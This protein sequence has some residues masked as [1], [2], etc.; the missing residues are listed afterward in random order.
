MSLDA[1]ARVKEYTKAL[2]VI[3]VTVSI[4]VK[5]N[6]GGTTHASKNRPRRGA[7]LC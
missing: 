6:D 4:M 1:C 3:Y 2:K 5:H 7:S